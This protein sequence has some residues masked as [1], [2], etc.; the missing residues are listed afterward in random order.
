MESL[1]QTIQHTVSHWWCCYLP[2][3]KAMII[4]GLGI[5][6]TIQMCKHKIKDNLK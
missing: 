3:L 5:V 6:G 4:P 2:T 1:F